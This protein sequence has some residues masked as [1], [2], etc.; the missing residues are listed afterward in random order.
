MFLFSGL[1][2][3]TYSNC[4]FDVF[5]ARFDVHELQQ[6]QF[7]LFSLTMAWVGDGGKAL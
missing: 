6:R 3:L 1:F 2:C 4:N 7:T 5:L